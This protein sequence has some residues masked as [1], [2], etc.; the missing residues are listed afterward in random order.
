MSLLAAGGSAKKAPRPPLDPRRRWPARSR[1][2]CPNRTSRSGPTTPLPTLWERCTCTVCWLEV[3]N[4]ISEAMFAIWAEIAPTFCQIFYF[5][6][7]YRTVTRTLCQTSFMNR[8]G[9]YFLLTYF[10]ATWSEVPAA[11]VSE[12][13][14]LSHSCLSNVYFF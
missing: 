3:R 5:L 14:Y 9:R 11:L 1:W 2:P 12:K 7:R 4:Y 13:R 6:S 10:F 8:C